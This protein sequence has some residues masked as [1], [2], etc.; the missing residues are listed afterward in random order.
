MLQLPWMKPKKTINEPMF[1]MQN[2]ITYWYTINSKDSFIL[3]KKE[4][5]LF[6]H[7]FKIFHIYNEVVK[8]FG[9][10]KKKFFAETSSNA[11]NFSFQGN[12]FGNELYLETFVISSFKGKRAAYISIYF[13]LFLNGDQVRG[14]QSNTQRG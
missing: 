1:P 8:V 5:S 13:V 11:G 12:I 3:E 14:R 9:A 10:E 6:Y 7:P 2:C 4:I